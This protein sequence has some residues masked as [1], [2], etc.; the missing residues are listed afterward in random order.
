MMA[1]MSTKND[2]LLKVAVLIPTFNGSAELPVLLTQLAAQE[3]QPFDV[4]VVDSSSTDGTAELIA[5]H[6][7]VTHHI[8]I[9]QSDFNH[10]AT[11]QYMIDVFDQY[12]VYVLLTQDAYPADAFTLA[13]AVAPFQNPRVGAVCGRQLPH[14]DAN[15]IAAHARLFNY[16][17]ESR[18]KSAADIPLLGIKVPFV[19][20][21]FT[22]YRKQAL[23][24]VGGFP[25]GVILSED[26]YV[27]A[28]MVQQ[29]WHIAYEAQ[30][31]VHHSHNYTL[32]QE[33]QRYFDIGVFHSR[34]AWIREAF[35]GA[36]G[37]GMRYVR[38]ELRYLKEQG[39]WHLAPLALW[40][41][42]GKLLAYKLGQKEAQLPL[43]LK[44]KFSMHK[45][46]WS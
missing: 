3:G 19:S 2:C 37:E 21:S 9:P 35:G 46:Y 42:A 33:W 1:Q 31:R 40:R 23:D 8:S 6:P 32:G 36:G 18:V 22:A 41:N 29:G 38:S 26:M 11:R 10:G 30:A 44:K 16:G 45:G 27:A 43:W 25:A 20:N 5:Q 39:Q 12:D 15:P 34:E 14:T 7:V 4:L 24:E 17:V 28:K 13:Q